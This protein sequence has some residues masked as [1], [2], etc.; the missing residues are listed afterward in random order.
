M[1]TIEV[2]IGDNQFRFKNFTFN[3]GEVGIKF[4]APGRSISYDPIC[5]IVARLR[6]PSGLTELMMV[7]DAVERT[8]HPSEV[9]LVL[10]YVPYA[11]QDRVCDVGEAFSLKVFSNFI[12]Y[13]SFKSVKI[14]DPHSEVA[15]ALLNNVVVVSQL[16]VINDFWFL[17]GR[18][19]RGCI[20]I[21]PDA[22]ANKKTAILAGR[23]GH[24]SYVRADK[25]RDLTNGQIKETI[26]YCDDFKGQDVIVCDDIIDGGASFTEIA[27]VCKA[28]NCG[29]FI[30]FA[31]HGI[32]SRGFDVLFENGIDEIYTTDSFRQDIADGRVKVLSV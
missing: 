27:K 16:E 7:K 29:K 12:N 30:L 9:G 21:S 8:F 25:A 31:T 1:N 23:F 24:T 22:G 2:Y 32:F 18:I 6:E 13:L 17:V 26:V 3:G 10:P 14:I 5:K 4:D 11:R 28:K 15:P 19:R 20:F